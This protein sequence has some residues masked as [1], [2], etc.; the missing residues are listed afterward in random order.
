[1][2]ICEKALS[3]AKGKSAMPKIGLLE[4]YPERPSDIDGFLPKIRMQLDL[5][6]DLSGCNPRDDG[7]KL[8]M[9]RRNLGRSYAFLNQILLAIDEALESLHGSPEKIG[10]HAKN[11]LT[12]YKEM[13]ALELPEH[14][15]WQFKSDVGQE[16]SELAF[17][18]WG[19]GIVFFGEMPV[20]LP[21][22]PDELGISFQAFLAG[23]LDFP[24]E[25][26]RVVND[27]V[28][29]RMVPENEEFEFRLRLLKLEKIILD[30]CRP[31]QLS[32]ERI[33]RNN[34]RGGWPNT[35]KGTMDRMRGAVMRHQERVMDLMYR[36]GA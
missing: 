17:T 9:Q 34:N 31:F 27:L 7:N 23:I 16:I 20:G 6:I 18:E 33:V 2:G 12:P 36:L 22:T 19:Y 28:A 25:M 5:I 14:L 24:G 1:M 35:F 29:L 30:I 10:T 3:A 8:E 11:I 4:R 15:S 26:G 32:Y 13:C 21:P